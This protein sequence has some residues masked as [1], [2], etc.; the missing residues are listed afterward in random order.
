MTKTKKTT[1]I[2]FLGGPG[3][4][5][6]TAAAHAY[7]HLKTLGVS[8]ELVREFVKEQA[9]EGKELGP[10]AQLH[11]TGEQIRRETLLFGKTAVVVTDSP[12][13]VGVE[14]ARRYSPRHVAKGVLEAVR[15]FYRQA[16]SEG[17]EHIHVMLERD[18]TR[19]P[20]RAEGRYQTEEEARRIDTGL[21]VLLDVLGYPVIR[22][23]PSEENV[24]VLADATRSFNQLAN[25]QIISYRGKEA[26]MLVKLMTAYPELSKEAKEAHGNCF[27]CDAIPDGELNGMPV[28]EC[29]HPQTMG[30]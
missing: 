21:N 9:W 5:K 13:L 19:H 22:L 30:G 20:Y 12:V 16:A 7:A 25:N 8:C 2:N 26:N 4:G 14:Y 1:V 24:K 15:A 6:S 27:I 10:Y 29:G 11:V 28:Y 3:I 23:N 17:H 18:S